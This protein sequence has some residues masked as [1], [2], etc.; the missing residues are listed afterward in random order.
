MP[1]NYS[2]LHATHK[3]FIPPPNQQCRIPLEEDVLIEIFVTKTKRGKPVGYDLSINSS[4]FAFLIYRKNYVI[5]GLI[6]FFLLNL[7]CNLF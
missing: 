6:H 5:F 1:P 7:K 4:F 3:H 2:V